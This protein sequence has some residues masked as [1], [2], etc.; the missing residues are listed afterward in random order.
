MTDLNKRKIMSNSLTKLCLCF[1]SMT[2]AASAS[3]ISLDT[4]EQT[5]PGAT[6]DVFVDISGAN[7][8]VAGWQFD[9]TFDSSVLAVVNQ[10]EGA[11][12]QTG[13]PPNSTFFGPGTVTFNAPGNDNLQGVNDATTGAPSSA[14]S[15]ILADIT[16]RVIS[17]SPT[18]TAIGLANVYLTDENYNLIATSVSSPVT[19]EIAPE[20][21]SMFLTLL[22]LAFLSVGAIRLKPRP[23]VGRSK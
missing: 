23:I 2:F 17:P 18:T 14:T 13:L 22:S 21:G 3:T 11:F 9:L 16:F 7:S 10:T 15:G 20:P 12:L 1:L 8:N 6:F 5:N 4:I 19:L